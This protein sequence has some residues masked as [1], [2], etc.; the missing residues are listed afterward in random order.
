MDEGGF[1]P[2]IRMGAQPTA[3]MDVYVPCLHEFLRERQ[4]PPH[5]FQHGVEDAKL[6]C[7]VGMSGTKF[8]PASTFVTNGLRPHRTTT[9]LEYNS[10][11]LP[12]LSR[13]AEPLGAQ[14]YSES[15]PRV[16]F[17]FVDPRNTIF[18]PASIAATVSKPFAEARPL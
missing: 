8:S 13:H 11:S 9:H 6:F 5:V 15:I 14:I 18:S 17:R 4:Q 1:A 3:R 12:E 10:L 7:F 16:C 2:W